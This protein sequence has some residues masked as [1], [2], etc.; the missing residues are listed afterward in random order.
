MDICVWEIICEWLQM[1]ADKQSI[2]QRE[3]TKEGKV[4]KKKV[5]VKA[6]VKVS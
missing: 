5:K 1:E 3:Q 4:K 2:S 6:K